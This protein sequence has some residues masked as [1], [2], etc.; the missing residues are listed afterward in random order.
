MKVANPRPTLPAMPSPPGLN[1]SPEPAVQQ[2]LP[3]RLPP[4]R[5]R[6]AGKTYAQRLDEALFLPAASPSGS[7]LGAQDNLARS[8]RSPS[9]NVITLNAQAKAEHTVRVADSELSAQFAATLMNQVISLDSGAQD[10]PET[11][12][13]YNIPPDSTFAKAWARLTQA[14]KD[15]PF[16][17]FAKNNNIDTSHF[18]LNPRSGWL[19]CMING[20]PANFT[21]YTPG[22]DAVSAAVVAAARNLAPTLESP[23]EYAGE[24]R[25][26][27]NI[28]GDFYGASYSNTRTDMLRFIGRLQHDHGFPCV[29]FSRSHLPRHH[30]PEH[31]HIQ[32]LQQDAIDTLAAQ[33]TQAQGQHLPARQVKTSSQL[34]A[35][36]DLELARWCSTVLTARHTE[37]RPPG[38]GITSAFGTVPEYS[39]FGQVRMALENAL[40]EPSFLTFVKNNKIDLSSISIAP[41]TGELTC[42]VIGA[43]GVKV[44]KVFRMT[45]DSGWSAVS[46]DIWA[47]AKSLA[48]GSTEQVRH[49][50]HSW[51]SVNELLNFYGENLATG[52]LLETLKRCA[53]L[54]YTGFPALNENAPAHNERSS[55]VRAK[56]RAVID[57][58]DNKTSPREATPATPLN[59]TTEIASRQFAGEPGLR[60]V[61]ARLLTD[62]LKSAS[63]GLDF[64]IN[65]LDFA[66]PDPDKPGQ[67]KR[68][69][70]MDLALDYLTDDAVPDLPAGSKLVDTRPDLMAHTGNTPDTP[71]PVEMNDLQSALRALPGQMNPALAADVPKYWDQPAFSTPA[72]GGLRPFAGSH[73]SLIS[74]LLRDN[75]RLAGLKQPGLDEQQRETLDLV[76]RYPNGLTRPTPTDNSEVTIFALGSLPAANQGA[77]ESTS[78]NLLIQ[79]HIAERTILLLCEPNGTVTPY[80]SY[81]AFNAAREQELNAQF[82]G[83]RRLNTLRKVDGHAF[84]NQAQP[85]IDQRLDH[86]LAS[87][88]AYLNLNTLDQPQRKMPA[89]VSQASEAERFVLRGLS[90]ELASFTQRNKGRTYNSDIPD[91][92]P[93][94]EKAFGQLM[95]SGHPAKNLEVV[96]RVPVGG[97]SPGGV[98]SGSIHRERL[99]MTDVL[100]RNLSGLPSRDVEVYLKPGN[101]RVPE[102]EV[103]GELQKLIQNIDVGKNYP[104]LL[105]RELLDDP[106]KKA[107][108]QSLFAQQIPVELQI[109]ALELAVQKQSGFDTTGLRYVQAAVNPEPGTKTVDGKEITVRPLAF[110]AGPGATPDVVD[111]MYLIEPEDSTSG[112]HILYRPLIADAPL[113]QFPTRQA[114]LEAIQQPGR[115][116]KDILAWFPDSSTREY[117]KA[118]SFKEPSA[119]ITSLFGVGDGE[120]IPAAPTLAVG[121]YAAADALKAKLQT[122]RLINHLYDANAQGLI[123]MAEQQSVSDAESRWATLKEG[124]YLLLNAV[125]PALRGPGAAIGTMLQFQGL[126]SDL[127]TLADDDTSN[128]EPAMADL[129]LNLAMLVTHRR[130]RPLPRQTDTHPTSGLAETPLRGGRYNSIV[131]APNGEKVRRMIV[132]KGNMKKMQLV[133]GNLFTFEDEYKGKPR[134]NINAHGRDLSFTEQLLG[135]SST[136]LYDGAEHTAEQLH[137]HLLA[138]GIDPSQFDNVRL[139]VCYSGN[140]SENSFA[141]EFQRLIK[142]PV[143]AFVGTV[144]VTPSPELVTSEFETGT[145]MHGPQNGPKLVSDTYAEYDSVDT[146]K[147]RTGISLIR[148]PLEYILFSYY[149]VYYPPRTGATTANR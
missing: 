61:M 57:R 86:S 89:W 44:Q 59:P 18:K 140:G 55:A 123:S 118:W 51:I 63:P 100:L 108:R 136:I 85:L 127:Q 8:R 112:P 24:D 132:M 109:K 107:E 92:R 14:L 102:L 50:R 6:G 121:S 149:P 41:Q 116:Q 87:A 98:V 90:L 84:D 139:L 38:E 137:A 135:K 124:G 145:Q 33:I 103:D 79:R 75:V 34:I 81:A 43:K 69:P 95:V 1:P 141:A 125:L 5:D 106:A 66:Q 36:G 110:I 39:T 94:A 17:T 64:D 74:D 77:I 53:A 134:L 71:L 88:A 148:N 72:S 114:L 11:R 105:K 35:K 27:L 65:H 37:T 58:L 62:A 31:R 45:D 13:V 46:T 144:T 12:L 119:Q 42:Q 97:N 138:K 49:P 76:V 93:F 117:Y 96:F 147:D 9:L 111:N 30:L 80:D 10:S 129:L 2:G 40:A 22:W 73:R 113:L 142:K 7:P 143:K 29:A 128:K 56:R 70:L 101:T 131:E 26:S 21:T 19:E 82:P 104:E 83:Q 15:E 54:N 130:A 16:A 3:L 60:A 133:K 25:A 68:T 23:F 67:F 47:S 99:S 20:Q 146:V 122:G 91:I 120:T 126:L 28:V 32:Q 52:T 78:P 4:P 48:A 115:L